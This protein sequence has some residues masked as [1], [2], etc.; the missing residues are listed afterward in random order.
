VQPERRKSTI[1]SVPSTVTAAS[2]NRLDDRHRRDRAAH[3]F[4]RRQIPDRAE[5]FLDAHVRRDD[6]PRWR[7]R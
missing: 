6:C 3:P 7:G 4:G 5:D 1:N 2:V